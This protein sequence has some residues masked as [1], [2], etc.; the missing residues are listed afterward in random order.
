MDSFWREKESVL[1]GK[2]SVF[3]RKEKYLRGNSS[4]NCPLSDK[5][6]CYNNVTCSQRGSNQ[7]ERRWVKLTKI[8][9]L[10]I[11]L[12]EK[13]KIVINEYNLNID[14]IKYLM[15]N[16]LWGDRK[17]WQ[18]IISAYESLYDTST[19]FQYKGA[20]PGRLQS[21]SI[22]QGKR[23]AFTSPF[24]VFKDSQDSFQFTQD[25]DPTGKDHENISTT[26]TNLVHT[27]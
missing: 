5:H 26:Y 23:G 18:G 21:H 16:I 6:F 8:D 15:Q 20:V 19:V 10:D 9:G 25:I 2:V 14:D 12:A 11:S 7:S 17:W 22:I 1:V 4:E 27:A 3:R 13:Q 24:F